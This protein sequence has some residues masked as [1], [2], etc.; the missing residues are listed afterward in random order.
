M[1]PLKLPCGLQHVSLGTHETEEDAARAYDLEL[2]KL[3]GDGRPL[4]FPQETGGVP[5]DPAEG[6]AEAAVLPEEGLPEAGLEAGPEAEADA[7]DPM[8]QVGLTL[9]MLL[10]SQD[11]GPW[12]GRKE[13][14][15]KAV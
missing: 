7:N 10:D 3:P 8:Q 15:A 13:Y 5:T 12:R 4:N 2:V 1:Q 6:S 14:K 11:I 9:P